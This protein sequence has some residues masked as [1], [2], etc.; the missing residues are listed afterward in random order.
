MIINIT[1]NAKTFLKSY[2]KS[3]EK[4]LIMYIS[5]TYPYTQYAYVNIT[6]CKKED[7]NKNDINISEKDIEIYID[8]K[9]KDL[10]ENS[11]IDIKEESLQI[12]APNLSKYKKKANLTIKDEIKVLF[13]NEINTVLS[14]HG[15]FIELV[16]IEDQENLI[17]KFHGGCQGCGMVNY[18]MNNY[19]ER[20]IKKNFPQIKNIK[21]I[22]AHEIRKNSYY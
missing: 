18:T 13:E 7:L 15:G 14:Q 10:L 11:I 12:N 22:T 2:I 8:D 5:V 19:I 17:I 16:D 6:F 1:N 20:I 4:N 9:S 3:E 21:D